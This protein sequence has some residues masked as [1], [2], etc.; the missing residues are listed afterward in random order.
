MVLLVRSCTGV[1][2]VLWCVLADLK[3]ELRTH[4]S[5]R[6][7]AT[8]SSLRTPCP[9]LSRPTVGMYQEQLNKF[10]F[11]AQTPCL[12]ISPP[13]SKA[14]FPDEHPTPPTS[15]PPTVEQPLDRTARKCSP[16]PHPSPPIVEQPL[17]R[18]AKH[19]PFPPPAS[20]G[21]PPSV[22]QPSDR[23]AKKRTLFQFALP[24]DGPTTFSPNKKVRKVLTTV[25]KR[26]YISIL[27][28]HTRALA[29]ISQINR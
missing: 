1:R 26:Y 8:R 3:S 25:R 23:T 6:K 20:S 18:V 27:H 5:T 15:P 22:E 29:A 10:S 16:F 24:S 12:S 17:D 9:P 14:M 21:S 28:I 7:R 11:P 2:G 4:E 19:T 13:S